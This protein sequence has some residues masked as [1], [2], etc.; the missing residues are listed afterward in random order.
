MQLATFKAGAIH[1]K[2]E[3]QGLSLGSEVGNLIVMPESAADEAPDLQGETAEERL[4]LA[5][6]VGSWA[7]LDPRAGAARAA[8]LALSGIV[9]V[10]VAHSCRPARPLLSRCRQASLRAPSR[11]RS[12]RSLSRSC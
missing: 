2:V 6:E 10:A 1:L 11:A 4:S 3:G 7:L 5:L 9:D 12:T 8:C